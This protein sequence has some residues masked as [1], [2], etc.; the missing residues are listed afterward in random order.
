MKFGHI[1]DCHLGGW[2]QPELQQLNIEY[3]RH[4]IDSCIEEKVDFILF[5]GDLFDSAFPPI[6]TLKDTFHEFRKLHEAKI[7][8]YVIA[9]SHDFSVSGKTFLDVIEKA[10]F[11]EICKYEE[12]EEEVLLKPIKHQNFM[13]YGYPGKKSGLEIPSL[14]KLKIL[15]DYKDGFRI[16]M[17]HTT[18]KNVTENLPI[19]SITLEELPKADYYALGH[20]HIDFEYEHEGKPVIYGGPTF[21][22]NFKELQDLKGGCFYII[23]VEGYT[24]VTKKEIKYKET[25][26]I[27]LEIED[28]LSATQKII[29]HLD[30]YNLEDKIIL[31]KIYGTVKKGRN[32]DINFQEVEKFLETKGVYSFLKNTSKLEQE[33]TEEL[34]IDLQS[35]EVEKVEEVLIKKYDKE[36]PSEFNHLI[37]QLMESLN[38]EKQ[39]AETNVTFEKRLLEGLNKVLS[40]DIGS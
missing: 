5:A 14:K 17:L 19:D 23:D 6:E 25:I 7:K 18:I 21:P 37:F 1:T 3:F 8:C 22:N 27:E 12:S 2:R 28:T 29:Q 24:K 34:K 39:E 9:G 31:L 35:K 33:K 15:E 36:N 20:I 16:L 38:L 32:S 30:N 13:I 26:Y 4:A 10:G 11:C 40:V